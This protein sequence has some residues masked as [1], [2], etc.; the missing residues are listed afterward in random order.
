MYIHAHIYKPFSVVVR[1]LKVQFMRSEDILAE[2][3]Y[4]QI[5][6]DHTSSGLNMVMKPTNTYNCEE[7]LTLY[8]VHIMLPTCFGQNCGSPPGGA[9]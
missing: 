2:H 6:H 7:Y 1:I 3:I 9:L 8:S 4:F 5:I